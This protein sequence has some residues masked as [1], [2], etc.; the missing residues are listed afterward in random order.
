[1]GGR[2]EWTA[3]MQRL[4]AGDIVTITKVERA[5]RNIA[6]MVAITKALANKVA[7]ISSWI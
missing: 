5:A 6:D 1:M 4:K 3:L 2:K 7:S